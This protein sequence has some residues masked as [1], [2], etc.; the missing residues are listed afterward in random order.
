MTERNLPVLLCATLGYAILLLEFVAVACVPA[1]QPTPQVPAV[2]AVQPLATSL[3]PSP[4]PPSSPTPPSSIP[5]PLGQQL[6]KPPAHVVIV[7]EENKDYEDVIDSPNAPYI[8]QLAKG[9]ASL[10]FF[11]FHHPSQ[12]NYF[13]LF[14]GTNTITYKVDGGTK[15][16]RVLDDSCVQHLATSQT[17]LGGLLGKDFL[18][19]AEGWD[20]N[21]PTA[22]P[23]P[24]S[25]PP[26]PPIPCTIERAYFARKHDPWMMFS[27]SIAAS[28]PITD[29]QVMSQKLSFDQLPLVSMVIPNLIDDM[30][31]TIT[32]TL[33]VT[34]DSSHEGTGPEIPVLVRTGNDWLK[35]NLDEYVK[36]AMTHNSLLIVTWDESSRGQQE[37]HDNGTPFAPPKNHIATILVGQMVKPGSRSNVVYDH[38]DLLRTIEDMYKLGP[39]LGGSANAKDILDIW[40]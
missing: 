29:F 17:S 9:G 14:A 35:S 16:E 20:P 3:P 1:V 15:P 12:P 37:G 5:A 34:T 13:E 8:N 25:T 38:Y 24:S 39:Y 23:P 11:A 32:D 7:I 27:D 19:Y 28:R 21:I 33:A 26:P 22:T 4:I 10:T 40:Q 36:W 6:T 30:H 18:G 2:P 31:S